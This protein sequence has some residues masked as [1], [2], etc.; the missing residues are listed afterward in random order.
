MTT[1]EQ[2]IPPN[3]NKR[4]AA[5]RLRAIADWLDSHDVCDHELYSA[6]TDGW[7]SLHV[8]VKPDCFSRLA[9]E[10][11]VS[12][13]RA[14][15]RLDGIELVCLLATARGGGFAAPGRDA[16]SQTVANVA[17]VVS[18]TGRVAG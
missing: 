16:A 17:G 6:S 12:N 11:T 7:D 3:H 15:V 5:S 4:L 8:H 14:C 2:Y 10:F 13:G 9:G 18:G 1:C